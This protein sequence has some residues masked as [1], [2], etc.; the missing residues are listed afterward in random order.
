MERSSQETLVKILKISTWIFIAI[1]IF[2]LYAGLRTEQQEYTYYSFVALFIGYACNFGAK[3][4]NRK[5]AK[6]NE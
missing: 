4:L 5:L 3:W 6:D 2:L 1:V